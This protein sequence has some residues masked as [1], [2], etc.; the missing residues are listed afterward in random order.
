MKDFITQRPWVEGSTTRDPLGRGGEGRRGGRRK[1]QL[2]GELAAECG[3]AN[4]KGLSCGRFPGEVPFQE[5]K[6]LNN[7]QNFEKSKRS[8]T[9][10]SGNSTTLKETRWLATTIP[11]PGKAQQPHILPIFTE[12]TFSLPESIFLIEWNGTEVWR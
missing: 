1:V 10:L 9:F 12:L 8:W 7:V 5:L 3:R 6:I 4:G 2:L 11:D